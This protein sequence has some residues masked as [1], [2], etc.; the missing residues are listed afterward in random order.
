MPVFFG[1][2]I[3]EARKAAGLTQRQLAEKI[4]VSNTSVSNWEK[5]LSRPDPDTIQNLCWALDVQ[6][7]YF[8]GSE[9]ATPSDIPGLS[10]MP[11]MREWKVIGATACG[12]PIHRE[13]DGEAVLAPDDID[14]DCV[15]RCV[16]DSMIG[17]HIFDG[18]LVFVK[19]GEYVE[20]GKIAVVRVSEE[21]SLKRIFRGADY[22]ELRSEN[23]AYSVQI[24]RGEQENAEIVGKAVYFLS[25][26]V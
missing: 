4:C 18:D 13:M 5:D 7:N 25:R 2:K 17:A 26:V 14:A 6:P 20:D 10:P 22:L 12:L 19:V 8:W 9:S 21:Y 11:K 23:P 15:F 16:G 1:E 3:R 24:I